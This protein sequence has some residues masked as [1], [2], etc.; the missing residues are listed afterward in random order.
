[1]SL[2]KSTDEKE[3]TWW[4]GLAG[5][6]ILLVGS[7]A[8]IIYQGGVHDPLTVGAL[9]L[10]L[11]AAY[12]VYDAIEDYRSQ[13]KEA[14]ESG[15]LS[16]KQNTKSKLRSVVEGWQAKGRSV[17][18]VIYTWFTVGF[19]IIFLLP[20]SE[21]WVPVRLLVLTLAGGVIWIRTG[22]EGPAETTKERM[23]RFGAGIAGVLSG[24]VIALSVRLLF[25]E[26]L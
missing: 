11:F 26:F 2:G 9:F 1:M 5:A 12:G 13:S 18:A 3:I 25:A 10:S 7:L 4:Q 22:G 14:L 16:S 24:L 6:L 19:T 17:S 21:W 8:H 20:P 23:K 15:T